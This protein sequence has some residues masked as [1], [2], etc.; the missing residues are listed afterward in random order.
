MSGNPAPYYRVTG[1]EVE[2]FTAA[3]ALRLP[4][5]LKGPTGTGKSRFLEYMAHSL[6]RKLITVVCNEETSAID[7]LG[8][9]LVKG[10]ETFWQD[11]PLATA[12]RSGAIFYLD[13]IAEARADILVAIHS[14]TDHRRQLFLDRKN[15]T[16]QAHENF[17]LVASFNPGYQKSFRELKPSTRQR[18]V[19]IDFYY[20]PQNVEVEI[21]QCETGLEKSTALK[22]V[23][24]AAQIRKRPELGLPETV[25]TRLL[26]LTAAMVSR[27][28]PL[29]LAA[30]AGVIL[31]LTDEPDTIAALED[32]AALFL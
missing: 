2:V 22:L 14:L 10:A 20:P 15:E 7:L 11:G 5:L 1:N 16:V 26:V 19:S 9:Y 4:V 3:A 17:L 27:G 6:G 24:L 21:I 12:V 8:R 31:P 25:S 30:R 28:V 23:Q 29:R 13:E 18:F 32:L